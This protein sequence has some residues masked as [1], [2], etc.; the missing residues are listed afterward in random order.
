W[1][2]LLQDYDFKIVHRPGIR[3]A[4]ADALSRNPV[5]EAMDDEELHREIQDDQC[6]QGMFQADER[7]LAVWVITCINSIKIIGFVLFC[8]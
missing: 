4:N 3:H 7:I 6:A 8:N 2:D 1:I 5:G